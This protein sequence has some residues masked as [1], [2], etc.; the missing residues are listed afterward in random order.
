MTR[1]HS[2]PPHDH[3]HLLGVDALKF[4]NDFDDYLVR[5]KGLAPGTRNTLLLLGEPISC[6]IQRDSK[7]R[8][9][10][11]ARVRSFL[12]RPSKPRD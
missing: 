1:T 12:I 8:L 7:A 5:I 2:D 4:L 9:V 6:E 3:R 10:V 11:P